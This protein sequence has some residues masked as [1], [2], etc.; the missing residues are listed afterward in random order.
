MD[1]GDTT[2]CLL[3]RKWYFD[4]METQNENDS[5]QTQQITYT[6]HYNSVERNKSTLFIPPEWSQITENSVLW[7]VSLWTWLTT[8][9][10]N[11]RERHQRNVL[12]CIYF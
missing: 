10:I 12:S 1:I 2:L 5:S 8:Y 7:K 9:G 11:E 4:V 6:S 3:L